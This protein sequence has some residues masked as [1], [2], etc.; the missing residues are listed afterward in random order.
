MARTVP[1][2]LLVED[3]EVWRDAI[4]RC[5]FLREIKEQDDGAILE[6]SSYEEAEALLKKQ[7]F[8]FAITDIV[9]SEAIKGQYEW[10]ALARM[11]QDRD[12]PTVVISAYLDNIPFV[13]E[14][15]NEYNVVGIFDKGELDPHKLSMHLRKIWEGRS[16]PRSAAAPTTPASETSVAILH[17][18]D[19][20]HG[21]QFRFSPGYLGSDFP[22]DGI[23]LLSQLIVDDL[24]QANISIDA[25]AISGDLVHSGES[26]QFTWARR[27]IEELL[28]G[29]ELSLNETVIVPGNHDV[30]WLT[31]EEEGLYKGGFNSAYRQFCES[32]RHT[33]FEDDSRLFHAAFVEDKNLAILGLDSCVIEKEETA[34]IGFVGTKQ[35][36]EALRAMN[37]LLKEHPECIKIA[38]LH[39]HL[40][41]V[42]P[43]KHLPES[44][45]QFSL[46]A[47]ASLVLRKLYQEGF[48]AILH[49]HQHQPYCADI[50]LHG[51]DIN[52]ETSMAIIGAGSAGVQRSELGTI[53]RNQYNIVQIMTSNQD[54]RIR[55]IGRQSSVHTE[56]EFESHSHVTFSLG[57]NTGLLRG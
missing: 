37:T 8:D 20:H 46:V 18:S 16:S 39:H 4:L 32:L 52:R 6:A 38:V 24:K 30:K 23:P 9:L 35:L 10:R 41:P 50:R 5:K 2:I 55:V 45:K 40:L 15:I 34:G 33:G 56:E 13:T 17:L 31:G 48:T 29:L 36:D 7:L 47:D 11:L 19:L 1:R 51:A 21:P 54:T 28:E 25:L 44:G 22:P 57:G 27:T 12:I 53:A 43:I 49:G 3:K 42:E 26:E 14:I